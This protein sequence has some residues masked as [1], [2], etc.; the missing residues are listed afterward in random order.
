MS[1]GEALQQAFDKRLHKPAAANG[2][3]DAVVNGDAKP[4]AA[5]EQEGKEPVKQEADG[6]QQ[7]P[8][9]TTESKEDTA[10]EAGAD[11]AAAVEPKAEPKPDAAADPAEQPKG[12]GTADANGTVAAAGETGKGAAASEGAA[13]KQASY[14]AEQLELLDWHWANLEYGCSAALT[15][16]SLP[17]WNQVRR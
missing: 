9:A 7:Q 14:T 3:T 16:V 17:H 12:A 15:E 5:E 2:S 6:Q 4:A 1:L 11:A 13:A 8:D 10:G